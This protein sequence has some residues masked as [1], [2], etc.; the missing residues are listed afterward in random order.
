MTH[1][2][3]D[4]RGSAMVMALGALAVLAV[5]A[6]A[7][8]AIV[9][10]EKRTGMSDYTGSRAFYTADAASEAGVNWIR[11]QASPP[12]PVDTLRYFRMDTTVVLDARDKYKFDVEPPPFP[13][14]KKRYRAG[15]TREWVD[16]EFRVQ[17]SGASSQ[18]SQAA[19]EVGATKLYRRG[20]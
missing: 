19:I 20:Y 2:S 10:A 12:I 14:P 18:Q 8:V 15:W 13:A 3:H 11:H 1:H 7:V 5:I 9:I 6:I 16:Y 4:E 17:A